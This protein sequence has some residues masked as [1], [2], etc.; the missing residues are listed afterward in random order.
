ML[1]VIRQ[2]RWL[3]SQRATLLTCREM[4]TL[5]GWGRTC[6][7]VVPGCLTQVSCMIDVHRFCLFG[8]RRATYQN[9]Q[10][11]ASARQSNRQQI[12]QLWIAGSEGKGTRQFKLIHSLEKIWQMLEDYLH[13][14]G[15][16]WGSMRCR[17]FESPPWIWG[18][19]STVPLRRSC[20]RG[21]CT[22]IGAP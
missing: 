17:V 5:V 3:R 18:S 4:P 6:K 1:N 20:P 9:I 8:F 16:V 7:T 19:C 14:Q 13:E 10:N 21:I 11:P 15:P 22:A 12:W 2:E